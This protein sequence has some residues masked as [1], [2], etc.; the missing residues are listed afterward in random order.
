MKQAFHVGSCSSLS[1]VIM[2]CVMWRISLKSVVLTSLDWS[3]LNG[4]A[5]TG[6]DLPLAKPSS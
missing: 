6:R 3:L 4:S 2:F 1:S 5:H